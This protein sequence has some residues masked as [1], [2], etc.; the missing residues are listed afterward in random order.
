MTIIVPL[1]V[2]IGC[3]RGAGGTSA[4]GGS[5]GAGGVAVNGGVAGAGGVAGNGGVGGAEYELVFADEF[6][7]GTS[8][9]PANWTIETG[10][11]GD[12]VRV[13]QRID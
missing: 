7:V 11:G 4:T 10:Y 3:S 1:T 13:Y 9:S 8:P 2:W 6:D 12:Y 5:G